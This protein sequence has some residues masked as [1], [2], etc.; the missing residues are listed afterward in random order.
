MKEVKIILKDLN[1]DKNV[2]N[3]EESENKNMFY[4]KTIEIKFKHHDD[5]AIIVLTAYT[6]QEFLKNDYSND[7]KNQ[8]LEQKY[9]FE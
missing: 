3:I 9:L 5:K 8:I 2:K 6:K 7:I 4:Q 1:L